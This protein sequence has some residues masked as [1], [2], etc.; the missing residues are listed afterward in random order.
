MG[1]K[2][3]KKLVS[4]CLNEKGE[5]DYAHGEYRCPKC[6]AETK[7]WYPRDENKPN[8]QYCDPCDEYFSMG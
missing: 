5:L 7:T 6:G 1:K 2:T 8:E 4:R 3:A